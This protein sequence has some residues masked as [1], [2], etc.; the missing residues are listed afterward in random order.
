MIDFF[1]GIRP[2]FDNEIQS[3]FEL[4]LSNEMFMQSAR[5]IFP[6]E[7][8]E[9]FKQIYPKIDT[10]NTFQTQFMQ[11]M[12]QL[13][14]QKKECN[15]TYS[16][17]ENIQ[18]SAIFLSNHRDIVVD[19]AFL[20]YILM[21]N[22]LVTTQV[23]FGNNLV[24]TEWI[25][26]FLRLNKSFIVKRNLSK[27]EQIAAFKELSAYIRHVITERNE[28]IWIAQ[29]EGRAKDSNDCT[30]P[31]ILKMFSL[32]GNG[33]LIDNLKPLN[34]C[35]LSISYEYDA[36]DYL[37]IKEF[38]QYIEDENFVKTTKDDVLSMQTGVIGYTGNL[39]YAF[40]SCINDELD[41]I[42]E[43]KLTRNEQVEM[44]IKIIDEKIYNSYKFFPINYLAYDKLY[45]EHNFEKFYQ[46]EKEN[47]EKYIE[48]QINKIDLPNFDR[49]IAEKRFLEMYSNTLKNNLKLRNN[50]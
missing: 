10:V 41:K 24:A 38:L 16:G 11:P 15:I 5:Q 22:G 28:S 26:V 1:S 49:E 29:R 40:N 44:I 36:C 9:N 20:Q 50:Q 3:A 23:A 46:N 30:Q 43:Q 27:G 19:P 25:L 39:H 47:L 34:I 35:P 2:Y 12:L 32:S 13:L 31:S 18:Q 7:I 42:A 6:N 33:N 48:N 8:I 21:L 45:N 4:L 17:F 14:L 37:K